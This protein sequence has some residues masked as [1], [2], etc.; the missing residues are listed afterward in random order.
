MEAALDQARRAAAA[1]ETPV[2]AAVFLG[3]RLLA[4]A[5]D[6]KDTLDDPTAHA[7]ILALREAGHALGDWRL[8]N[9]DL[10]VTLEPCPMC[11]GAILQSRVRRLIFGARSPRWGAVVSRCRLLDEPRFNHR[12]EWM[13]GVRAA[14]CAEILQAWFRARR[15]QGREVDGAAEG[16]EPPRDFP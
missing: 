4:A 8:E 9:C 14:E 11:A 15:A 16:P 13:E 6:A 5:H 1:E 2:G 7:E 12:V 10:V 3:A